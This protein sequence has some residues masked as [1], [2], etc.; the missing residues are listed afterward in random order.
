MT[1][2][3]VKDQQPTSGEWTRAE[4]Q[5]VF[6]PRRKPLRRFR[7]AKKYLGKP[8]AMNRSVCYRNGMLEHNRGKES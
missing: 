7:H 6:V 4:G 2:V 1:R 3:R 8:E 5:R